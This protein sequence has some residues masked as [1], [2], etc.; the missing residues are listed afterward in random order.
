MH[1]AA[2]CLYGRG[3]SGVTLVLA[4]TEL[5]APEPENGLRFSRVKATLPLPQ[6]NHLYL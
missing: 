4:A 1:C 5:G 2:Y 6:K 3:R